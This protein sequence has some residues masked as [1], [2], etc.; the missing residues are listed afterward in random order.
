MEEEEVQF[1]VILCHDVFFE[2]LRWGNRRQLAKLERVG[3]RFHWN[4]ERWFLKTP[5]LRLD[6]LIVP[7]FCLLSVFFCHF[8]YCHLFSS[9]SGHGLE[10][11]VS[12]SDI[13]DCNK[14]YSD[15]SDISFAD[16][17]LFLLFFDSLHFQSN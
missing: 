8:C 11:E 15:L 12:D 13:A 1:F 17:K 16:W 14:K 6:L 2:V 5:F 7:R 3:K 9:H 4:V 10:V